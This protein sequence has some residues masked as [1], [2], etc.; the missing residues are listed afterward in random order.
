MD[1]EE[2]EGGAG[3]VGIGEAGGH[4]GPVASYT[5]DSLWWERRIS[6]HS[7]KGAGG[8]GRR[9]GRRGASGDAELS[10]GL[11]GYHWLSWWTCWTRGTPCPCRHTRSRAEKKKNPDVAT[12]R[13]RSRVIE[14]R[15]FASADWCDGRNEWASRRLASAAEGVPGERGRAA[16]WMT[17]HEGGAARLTPE[18]AHQGSGALD[19]L[20]PIGRLAAMAG[21]PRMTC[22]S[23]AAGHETGTGSVAV[24]GAGVV[25]SEWQMLS[26]RDDPRW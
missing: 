3:D 18:G 12:C 5:A 14:T 20:D 21:Y 4:E 22:A 19:S 24:N 15:S 10:R 2:V 9:G 17:G 16:E 26:K 23:L 1:E 8:R 7:D 6:V 11:L 13:V 25:V